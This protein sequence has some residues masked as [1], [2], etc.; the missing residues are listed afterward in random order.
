MNSK[1][2]SLI[3]PEEK[4]RLIEKIQQFFQDERDE[5]I[6]RIAA[7]AL[8]D[9]FRSE[10]E[11]VIMQRCIARYRDRLALKLEDAEVEVLHDFS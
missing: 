6:G 5:E 8:L 11:P 1:N 10:L 7:D 9:F 2:E 4:E 3:L